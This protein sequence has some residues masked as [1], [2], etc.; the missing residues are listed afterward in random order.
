MNNFFPKDS[1]NLPHQTKT[2]DQLYKDLF[3]DVNSVILSLMT[4]RQMI[5]LITNYACFYN[6]IIYYGSVLYEIW[7]HSKY[8][9]GK[10]IDVL[11]QLNFFM[12]ENLV[13]TAHFTELRDHENECCFSDIQTHCYIIDFFDNKE[14]LW[15]I[16]SLTTLCFLQR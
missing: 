4:G 10:K 11:S 9:H 6:V 14:T 8:Y 7:K 15:C 1:L 3:S 16:R 13:S 12:Q 5:S 2:L